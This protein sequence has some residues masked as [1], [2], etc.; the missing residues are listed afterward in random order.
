MGVMKDLLRIISE[1]QDFRSYLV[2]IAIE[3]VWNL[4]EVMGQAAVETVADQQ[5]IVLGLKQPFERVLKQGYKLDDKCLRNEIQILI[6]YI[7]T[8]TKSHKFF[9][10]KEHDNDVCFLDTILNYATHDEMNSQ[11]NFM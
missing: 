7:A 6:N 10:E 2:H 4:I 1:T 9:L 8:S 5:E 3:A 11:V